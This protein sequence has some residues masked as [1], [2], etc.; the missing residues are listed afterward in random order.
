MVAARDGPEAR[1]AKPSPHPKK[2]G[3][4]DDLMSKGQK[5]GVGGNEE[6]R[7]NGAGE[8]EAGG[9]GAEDGELSD[10]RGALGAMAVV[11]PPSY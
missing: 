10:G 9:S 6:A 4:R 3:E 5:E 11:P 8:F 1:R 2:Q 7:D